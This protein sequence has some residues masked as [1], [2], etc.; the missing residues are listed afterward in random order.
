MSTSLFSKKLKEGSYRGVLI[1]NE[2]KAIDL[3]FNFAVSYE[4]RKPIITIQNADERIVVDEIT[5]KGDS[6]N[7]KMPFFDTE[8][9]TV[10]VGN[11]LEGVWI[12]HYKTSNNIIK[13]KATYNE[14][15]RFLFVPEKINPIFEG[16]WEVSFSP[17]SA[18]SS[19]AIGV[20]RHIEQ[21]DYVTGTFL[22]ETGDYRYLEGM[23]TGNKLYL[24]AFD[25]SHAFLFVADYSN[26]VLQGVFYSGATWSEKW[27]GI[28][29]ENFKLQDAEEIS[30]MKNKDENINFS[31]PNLEGK[32]ISLAD[33]KFENK[34]V[35][36][37][38]MGSWCPNCLDESVYF[39]SLYQ[40]YKNS[41]LEIIALA[42]EKTN[43]FEK[44]QKQVLRLKNR[45]NINYE[46]LITQQTGK[47][48]AGEVL[49]ALNKITAFPTTLFLNK[50]HQVVKV[51]TGFSGPATGP[52]YEVYKKR[53]ENLINSL[54]KD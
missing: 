9:K 18:D 52:D 33:K 14:T 21:T 51:H 11:N 20:F 32:S 3:P 15:K 45:L 10:R 7:F 1:L 49:S 26:G 8:F 42:F 16:K 36:I 5:I 27:T 37:Q 12:N 43:D 19:K 47:E 39:S 41:G 31:F 25:G 29:N 38:L 17:G 30:F 40:N 2:D 22:T 34:P 46:I 13:F 53:T 50:K 23:K 54:L 44:A 4:K 48:K 6:I 35:I 24:S 28:R